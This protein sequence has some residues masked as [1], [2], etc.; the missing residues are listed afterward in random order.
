[1]TN[2]TI[3]IL[4]DQ[5][6]ES[7]DCM[8]VLANTLA[9]YGHNTTDLFDQV[10]RNEHVIETFKDLHVVLPEKQTHIFKQGE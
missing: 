8:L 6:E 7:N 2:N 4:C 5:L 1:M 9:K 10:Y 3:K